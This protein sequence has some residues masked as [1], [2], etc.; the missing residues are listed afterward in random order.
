MTLCSIYRLPF[1]AFVMLSLLLAC[2]MVTAEEG[3]SIFLIRHAE[4]QLDGIRDPSLT[5]KGVL[6]AE[7]I[8]KQLKNRNIKT[9]YST[10]YKRTRQTAIPLSKLL[11][12][13]L[14]LYDPSQLEAFAKQ[15]LSGEGNVLIVG[16]SNT[17]PQ[18]VELLG[19][20]SQGP[21]AETVYNRIYQ[22]VVKGSKVETFLLSSS[23]N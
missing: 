1:L 16:H 21:M 7:N 11:E 13:G 8:S 5:K 19:G 20:N 9:I 6:R 12:I 22:L 23:I 18:L 4:K 17:T 3:R 15:V 14:A 2:P 10:N